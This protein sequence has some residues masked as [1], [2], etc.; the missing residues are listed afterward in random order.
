MA[1]VVLATQ[2]VA[3]PAITPQFTVGT[4]NGATYVVDGD[5]REVEVV[6]G[7][8][9]TRQITVQTGGTLGGF[10]VA[11]KVV[12]IPTGER[13]RIPLG[14]KRVYLRPTGVADAGKIYVDVDTVASVTAGAF[15]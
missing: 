6:N 7:S 15:R 10:A 9:G 2:V 3:E 1:R 14:D 8:G 13:R 12:S 5:A 11:D 4:D